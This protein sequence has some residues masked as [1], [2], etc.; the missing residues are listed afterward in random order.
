MYFRGYDAGVRDKHASCYLY[1]RAEDSAAEERSKFRRQIFLDFGTGSLESKEK[2]YYS[3]LV[4][5]DTRKYIDGQGSGRSR[6]APVP[7]FSGKNEVTV[8]I[9]I[10]FKSSDHD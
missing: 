4:Q 6:L 2:L 10:Y 5:D 7:A 9:I 3:S 8:G 1:R